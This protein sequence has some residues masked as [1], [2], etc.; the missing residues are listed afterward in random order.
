MEQ[1]PWAVWRLREK[2]GFDGLVPNPVGVIPPN[3][4]GV[5]PLTQ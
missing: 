1:T 3:T 2:S 4:V 5:I